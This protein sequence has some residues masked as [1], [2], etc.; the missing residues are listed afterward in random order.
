[1]TVSCVA[2]THG[3]FPPATLLPDSPH[4]A[5]VFARLV[6]TIC[7]DAFDGVRL[8]C[9]VAPPSAD[10]ESYDYS[11]VEFDDDSHADGEDEA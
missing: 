5:D 4:G 1:M 7:S 11:D 3:A 8:S 9:D 10:D 6:T 2:T